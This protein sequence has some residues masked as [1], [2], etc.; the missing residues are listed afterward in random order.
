VADR[1]Q[2]RIR[3]ERKWYSTYDR[4]RPTGESWAGL[5]EDEHLASDHIEDD[6]PMEPKWVRRPFSQEERGSF[7]QFP[8]DEETFRLPPRARGWSKPKWHKSSTE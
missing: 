8:D 2:E 1:S 7:Q 3:F 4:P 5:Y 6:R